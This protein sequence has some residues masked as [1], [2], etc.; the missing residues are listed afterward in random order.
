VACVDRSDALTRATARGAIRMHAERLEVSQPIAYETPSPRPHRWSHGLALC[1]SDKDARRGGR[2]T[3]TELGPDQDAIREVDRRS[4]LFDMGLNLAQCDFCVR[5]SDRALLEVLR[6]CAGRSVFESA[7]PAMPAILRIHPHRIAL[8]NL[9]RVEVYQKIGGP[10]TGGVSPAGPHTHVLPKLL[11][12]GR[13]HSANTPIPDG[14]TPCAYV[15]PGNPVIGP[16][17][18]DRCFDPR[19][20]D[21]FQTLL[22][23]FGPRDLVDTKNRLISHLMAGDDGDRGPADALKRRR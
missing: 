19:L 2:S 14:L 5:T 3:L 18:E 4:I 15:Y 12:S 9:G 22:Q 7:N 23:A 13:T 6:G 20:H 21:A 8:T 10:E 17:G 16:L 11:R 1:L